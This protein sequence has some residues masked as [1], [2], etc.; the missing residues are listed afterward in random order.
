MRD[1]VIENATT[2]FQNDFLKM[3]SHMKI[4]FHRTEHTYGGKKKRYFTNCYRVRVDLKIREKKSWHKNIPR[5]LIV[6]YVRES[7]QSSLDSI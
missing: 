7:L 3:K 1:N 2:I 6:R 4:N 5:D